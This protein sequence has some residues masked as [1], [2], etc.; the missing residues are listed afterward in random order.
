MGYFQDAGK[1]LWG[2][3]KL[4]TKIGVEAVKLT[5]EAAHHSAKFVNKHQDKIVT[6]TNT[7]VTGGAWLLKESGSALSSGASALA[8]ELH[9]AGQNAEGVAG[10]VLGRAAGYTVDAV[11]VVGKATQGLG[12]LTEKSASV[13]GAATGSAVSGLVGTVSGAVDSVAITD[14]DFEELQ[15]RLQKAS[16]S[17]REQSKRKL[18]S[19]ELAQKQRKK[20]DLLDLL[21]V[22]GITL[23]EML[24]SPAAIPAEIEQAF[25]LAYP[26]LVRAGESFA[27]AIQRTPTEDLVGFV[28]SVKGKLFELELVDHLNAGNLPD[29]L[30]AQL[31][32]SATQPGF[33]LQI[34]DA[35][36]QVVDILQAKATESVVYV[37]Q[38]LDRYP[39]IDVVSTTEV[40]AQLMALGAAEQVSSVGITEAALQHK[41][42]AAV[43]AAQGNGGLSDWVPPS[44]GLAIIALSTFMDKSLTLEQ[45]GAEFGDRAAKLTVTSAAANSVLLVTNTWWIGL[46]VGMG[47]HWLSSYGG[48]KRQRYEALLRM[49]N[50]LELQNKCIAHPVS[51]PHAAA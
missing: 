15:Q 4:T 23:A 9:Q 36:G 49:V 32:G 35:Q 45:K 30:Y 48:N 13:V 19:I 38:A 24:R 14:K 46:A 26:G 7:C 10:K 39:N 40:H 51:L 16:F 47:S 8:K 20:D 50:A 27:E 41:V 3:S 6:A 21:V 22:G 44:I 28:S 29:G 5:G 42:E 1:L 11:G 34:L 17:Y 43:S 2:A 18:A 37:Q 25:S 12:N 33:D 31:A